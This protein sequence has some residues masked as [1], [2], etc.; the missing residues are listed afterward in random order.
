MGALGSG[1]RLR[2][3]WVGVLE[4]PSMGDSVHVLAASTS[5][6]GDSVHVLAA[7]T[8]CRGMPAARRPPPAAE[9]VRDAEQSLSLLAQSRG[10]C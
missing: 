10:F 4:K 6:R 7:S 2:R 9:E 1:Q 5:C 8:S 3:V